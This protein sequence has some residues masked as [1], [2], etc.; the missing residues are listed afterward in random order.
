MPRHHPHERR[1]AAL[2]HLLARSQALLDHTRE[3]TAMADQTLRT[4]HLAQQRRPVQDVEQQVLR[5]LIR[6]HARD[7]LPGAP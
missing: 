4:A 5:E 3:L 7:E 6:R 1:I 2:L